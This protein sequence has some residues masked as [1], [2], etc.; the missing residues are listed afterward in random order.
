MKITRR[1]LRQ[2]IKEEISVLREGLDLT[3]TDIDSAEDHLESARAAISM[4]NLTTS[5]W[6]KA[7][8]EFGAATRILIGAEQTSVGINNRDKDQALEDIADKVRL[9]ADERQNI[10][11]YQPRR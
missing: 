1:K 6:S 4:D 11:R 5:N 3:L 8:R 10:Q 2:I 7:G 9:A